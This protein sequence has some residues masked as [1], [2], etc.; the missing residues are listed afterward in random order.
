NSAFNQE[1]L[2]TF[3]NHEGSQESF[4]NLGLG[5]PLEGVRDHL[6]YRNSFTCMETRVPFRP[7]RKT[8]RATIA[9]VLTAFVDGEGSGAR[10]ELDALG[11]YKLRFPFDVSGRKNGNASCW[12][13]MSQ[14]QAGKRSGTSFPLLPGTEVLVSFA[15]GNPDRPYITGALNNAETGALTGNA[16][17]DFSGIS[18]A[19]GNQIV[20]N[21]TEKGQGMALKTAG[22]DGLVLNAGSASLGSLT[23]DFWCNSTGMAA[24][25]LSGALMSSFSGYRNAQVVGWRGT[26]GQAIWMALLQSVGS[27]GSTAMSALAGSYEDHYDKSYEGG[28]KPDSDNTDMTA[29]VGLTAGVGVLKSLLNVLEIFCVPKP[30]MSYGLE[31]QTTPDVSSTVTQIYPDKTKLTISLLGT[32]AEKAGLGAEIFSEEDSKDQEVAQE[33][34]KE[35]RKDYEQASKRLA[36]WK[37]GSEAVADLAPE[38]IAWVYMLSAHL[39]IKKE[40]MG[41][42]L[43]NAPEANITLAAKNAVGVHSEHGILLNTRL[44]EFDPV[45]TDSAIGKMLGPYAETG[46]A[47][48]VDAA[49][50]AAA[51]AA[52]AAVGAP[53]A[54]PDDDTLANAQAKAR[55]ARVKKWGTKNTDLEIPANLFNFY[56]KEA[57]AY[58][59]ATTPPDAIL[60]AADL[61]FLAAVTK[62]LYTDAEYLAENVQKVRKALAHKH[63]YVSKNSG[64]QSALVIQNEQTAGD[65]AADQTP[66]APAGAAGIYLTS[67][68]EEG[69]I[70]LD[71][72]KATI[73]LNTD[74]LKLEHKA[75]KKPVVTLNSGSLNLQLDGGS[76]SINMTEEDVTIKRG[77]ATIVVKD[78]EIT[79]ANSGQKFSLGQF[80]FTS[81]GEMAHTGSLSLQDG[82]IKIV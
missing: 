55:N 35:N 53:A 12:I 5:I 19:G 37:A 34:S 13:R 26:R 67:S 80:T 74:G 4:L 73:T 16:N 2:V 63:I 8:P 61:N 68:P 20:F 6:F 72:P 58:T 71:T 79:M 9:G 10:P 18:S 47:A 78:G 40:Q 28:N 39:K 15:D 81:A 49:T 27:L 33:I 23:S 7:E 59:L 22:G 41:G 36:I 56:D 3:V 70:R 24:T 21:D 1:Y 52:A 11:R 32:L 51:A 45:S 57:M 60:Q 14:Q 44:G 77:S 17:R 29:A 25:N 48:A 38:I 82:A 31:M 30:T 54:D 64:G 50:A 46:A 65:V 76:S 62:L 42:V 66:Q 69:V 75:E 43:L